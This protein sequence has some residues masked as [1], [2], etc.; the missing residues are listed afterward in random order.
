MMD[1]GG[2]NPLSPFRLP[3]PDP[4]P[5][6]DPKPD[7]DQTRWRAKPDDAHNRMMIPMQMNRGYHRTTTKTARCM[8]FD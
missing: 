8:I 6:G 1:R 7:D 4:K 5:D 3:D 2:G